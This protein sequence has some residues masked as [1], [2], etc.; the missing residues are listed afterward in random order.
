[1]KKEKVWVVD[2]QDNPI[3]VVNREDLKAGDTW[4]VSSV[5]LIDEGGKVLISQRESENKKLEI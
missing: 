5:I 2:E 3:K 1:M 4:R